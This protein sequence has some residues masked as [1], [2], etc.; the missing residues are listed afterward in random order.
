[1]YE[2]LYKQLNKHVLLSNDEFEECLGFF[3]FRKFR[4]HQYILQEGDISRYENF[5]LKGC[6]RTYEVDEKGEEHIVQF[7]LEDGGWGIYSVSSQKR[8]RE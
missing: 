5:L 6:T 4:K 7:G 8:L 1:M 2:L 3:Q